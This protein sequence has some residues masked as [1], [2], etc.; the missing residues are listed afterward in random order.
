MS[1]SSHSLSLLSLSEYAP[2][3]LRDDDSFCVVLGFE[4]LVES[5]V[6]DAFESVKQDT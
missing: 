3:R 6:V 2:S 5:V 1:S 4:A